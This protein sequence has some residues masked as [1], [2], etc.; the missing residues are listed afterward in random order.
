MNL[1]GI[2]AWLIQWGLILALAAAGVGWAAAGIQTVRLAHLQAKVATDLAAATQKAREREQ[3]WGRIVQEIDDAKQ[4]DLRAVAA[5]RDAALQQL[6]N[7]PQRLPEAAR[8]AC[9]GGTG[10]ELSGPDAEFLVGLAARADSLRAELSA[11][12]QR[13]DAMSR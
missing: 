1:L 9:Q 4:T 5:Q 6:R 10:A 7:R 12:Y 2:K 13:E 8:A 11:C 3:D